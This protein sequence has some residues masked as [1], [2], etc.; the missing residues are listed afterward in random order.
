MRIGIVCYPTVGGSGVVATE[1]ALALAQR[2]HDAIAPGKTPDL[3]VRPVVHLGDEPSSRLHG[4]RE[5]PPV[6]RRIEVVEP[7]TEHHDRP[8]SRFDRPGVSRRVAADG[9]P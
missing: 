9:T 8:A 1:M 4:P 3:G 2:G 7:A 5:E 6:H